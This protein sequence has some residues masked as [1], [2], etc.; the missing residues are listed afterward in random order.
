MKSLFKS[1]KEPSLSGRYIHTESILDLLKNSSIKPFVKVIGSSVNNENIYSITIGSGPK[2]ILMWSQMH[3][4]E[5][6]TTKAVFDMINVFTASE[7]VPKTILKACTLKIIPILNPDGAKAYT[8]LN[9]NHIDLNRDAQ[10]LSQPESKVL[11]QIFES[12]KPDYCFNLHG[13]RTI[14]SAGKANNPATV[15]FLAPAQDENCTITDTRKVAMEIISVMN[16][17]LQQEIPNQVGIY[18]DAFN[19][20][21]VGDTFQNLNVP[22]VLF[23][24]G[25]F[26]NDYQREITREYIFQSLLIAIHY[27]SDNNV[28]GNK[29]DDYLEIPENQKLFYDII[30]KNTSNEDVGI[31]YIEKLIDNSIHFVPKIEKI[32][33]LSS[34]F[35]HKEINARGYEVL[36]TK[37]KSVSEGSENVFVSINNEKSSLKLKNN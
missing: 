25:H 3:G 16:S 19:L 37:G 22:T 28:T 27:I 10:E 35:S 17:H 32:S 36:T 15:S 31:Q 9:A 8:R 2:K 4:N 14:F 29:Y 6:T 1:F 5:S 26:A 7:N 12:F 18:D 34:Y 21:C 23:E 30:I 13:Q 20:N 24:A 33:D 11:K